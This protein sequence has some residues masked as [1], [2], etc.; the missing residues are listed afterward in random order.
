MLN[1]RLQIVFLDGETLSPETNLK[2]FPFEH[3]LIIYAKSTTEQ[4]I[5]R[6]RGA[7]IIISNKVRVGAELIAQAPDLKLISVAATGYNN[8]DMDACRERGVAVCNVRD[9]AKHTVPEHVFALIFALR[10]SLLPYHQSVAAGRWQDSGQFCYFD[11]PIRD[12]AGSTLAIVGAGSLGESVAAMGRALGLR[13][14][15]SARKNDTATPEGRVS[16]DDMLKQADIISL[17]CPLT[18]DTQDLL[19]APEFAQMQRK[20]LII[21]TARGG[22]INEGDLANALNDGLISGAG[23]DVTTPEPPED[24]NILLSLMD[25]PNFIFTPHV[26]WASQEAV[27]ALADQ[28][29]DNVSAFVAGTPA[30]LL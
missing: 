26:A 15:F 22:L 1:Q 12:L 17:H 2:T 21:N 29:F 9:Y 25:R 23:I 16:F 20:P 27:Q 6:C 13:V 19:A 4:A 7:H 18:A 24:D 3:D 10:R 5:E 14:I 8:I 28:A 11:Y 30:N